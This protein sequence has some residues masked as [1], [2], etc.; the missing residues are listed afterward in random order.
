M[1]AP[2]AAANMISKIDEHSS[3]LDILSAKA[4]PGTMYLAGADTVNEISRNHSHD[5]FFFIS[6][7]FIDCQYP[8]D[9][10]PRNGVVPGSPAQSAG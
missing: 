6:G 2:S 1:A 9:I 7:S 10:H 5:F 4:V 3:E 8:R